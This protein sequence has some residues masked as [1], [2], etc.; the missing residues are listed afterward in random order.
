[1]FFTLHV[2][3]YFS[4]SHFMQQSR[5]PPAQRQRYTM[6][7]AAQWIAAHWTAAHWTAARWTAAHWTACNAIATCL[8][9]LPLKGWSC[10]AANRNWCLHERKGTGIQMHFIFF[11]LPHFYL[12]L[13]SMMLSRRLSAG[14]VLSLI[15][16]TKTLTFHAEVIF[17]NHKNILRN[18]LW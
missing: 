14:L 16:G 3:N 12:F 1:M 9:F 6:S 5:I 18:M 2:K 7:V 13:H 11:A 10:Q 8:T 17:K 15:A 4:W